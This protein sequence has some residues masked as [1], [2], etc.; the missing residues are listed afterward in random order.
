MQLIDDTYKTMNRCLVLYYPKVWIVHRLNSKPFFM[1][2]Q[3]LL[4]YG[5]AAST[6]SWNNLLNPK[7][8]CR[9]FT[10]PPP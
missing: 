6:I 4:F 9:A 2:Y 5:T 3:L 10:A 1:L 7:S 8:L